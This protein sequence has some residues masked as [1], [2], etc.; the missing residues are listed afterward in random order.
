MG[1]EVVCGC[2]LS[3]GWAPLVVFHREGLLGAA[4]CHVQGQGGLFA[5]GFGNGVVGAECI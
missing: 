3:D 2:W 4:G 1:G 5:P